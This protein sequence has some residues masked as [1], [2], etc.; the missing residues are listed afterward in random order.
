MLAHNQCVYACAHVTFKTYILNP[1]SLSSPPSPVLGLP[2]GFCPLRSF[3][4]VSKLTE[5]HPPAAHLRWG[6]TLNTLLSLEAGSKPS[7]WKERA[8]WGL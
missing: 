2:A 6:H 7:G 8:A 3:P 4:A 1:F 5:A